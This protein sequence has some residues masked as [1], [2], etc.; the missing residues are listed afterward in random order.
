VSYQYET[1]VSRDTRANS[2]NRSHQR[3]FVLYFLFGSMIAAIGWL[4]ESWH[5]E[6]FY[7]IFRYAPYIAIAGHA[8]QLIALFGSMLTPDYVDEENGQ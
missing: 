3:F 2:R 4:G 6:D 5:L 7:E 1:E 8:L